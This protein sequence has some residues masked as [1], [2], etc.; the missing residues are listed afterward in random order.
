MSTIIRNT[1][2]GTS[3]RIYRWNDLILRTP[4]IKRIMPDQKKICQIGDPR[5][6]DSTGSLRGGFHGNN[7]YSNTVES[8]GHQVLNFMI[9]GRP[10]WVDASRNHD[11]EFVWYQGAYS[12]SASSIQSGVWM[13]ESYASFPG[14]HFTLPSV[15]SP[16]SIKGVKVYYLNMGCTLAFGA[17]INKNANNMNIKDCGFADW[18]QCW[19][20]FH[21][22]NTATCNYH[23]MDLI[24]NSPYDE[25]DLIES[26][27]RGDYR[28]YRDLFL[29]APMGVTDGCIPT[30]T[31]PL[32][33]SYTM[34]ANTMAHFKQN[35]AGWIVP[36]F[37]PYMNNLNPTIDYRPKLIYNTTGTDNYWGCVSLRD[38]YI[39]VMIDIA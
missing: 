7:T 28:E 20:Q 4:I 9:N 10:Q 32:R 13:S 5:T 16:L 36:M 33:Q 11:P 2:S 29:L 8:V 14:F 22:L 26:G 12:T 34:S 24:N 27:G 23:P 3:A 6:A 31:N 37:N 17:A 35:G 15:S 39:D 38:V 21:V 25:I 30:L 18:S 19:C 1:A